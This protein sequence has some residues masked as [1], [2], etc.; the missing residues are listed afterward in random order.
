ML[1]DNILHKFKI[2]YE[3]NVSGSDQYRLL[4][5]VWWIWKGWEESDFRLIA[6]WTWHLSGWTAEGQI[7]N[8]PFGFRT[9]YLPNASL[10]QDRRCHWPQQ[11]GKNSFNSY[12]R[13]G[14]RTQAV[15]RMMLIIF[16]LWKALKFWLLK[17]T[18]LLLY[19]YRHR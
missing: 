9:G 11:M 14:L 16:F 2:W 7:A 6:V 17:I 4:Y 15:M 19:V 10:G 8:V 3:P 18:R 1:A 13:K 12:D 5:D